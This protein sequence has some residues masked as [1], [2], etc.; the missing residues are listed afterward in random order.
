MEDQKAKIIDCCKK[1]QSSKWRPLNV[2][3]GICGGTGPSRKF[4]HSELQLWPY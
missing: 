2:R 4:S 1:T 3:V